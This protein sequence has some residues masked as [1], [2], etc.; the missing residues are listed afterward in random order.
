LVC[1]AE[2][3]PKQL[4]GA[5]NLGTRLTRDW[6]NVGHMVEVR[7]AQKNHIRQLYISDG[8]ADGA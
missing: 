5:Y 1:R 6:D 8:E 2:D 3:K 4:R 7:V